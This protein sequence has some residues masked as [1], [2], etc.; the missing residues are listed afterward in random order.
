MNF[1]KSPKTWS[2]QNWTSQTGSYPDTTHLSTEP[3]YL[4]F[5]GNLH[6]RTYPTTLIYRG[7]SKQ[8]RNHPETF[9][10]SQK[11]VMSDFRSRTTYKMMKFMYV[12]EIWD[13]GSA[14]KFATR[15]ADGV[16]LMSSS[17]K[18]MTVCED[19]GCVEWSVISPA[20]VY[21]VHAFQTST[22]PSF[23]LKWTLLP[24]MAE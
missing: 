16:I 19:D 9:S 5:V 6:V 1:I 14:L 3:V 8:R 10:W 24:L 4:P 17:H 21:Y 12:L 18:S 13:I 7:K 2:G 23:L 11:P 20:T 22:N 15:L